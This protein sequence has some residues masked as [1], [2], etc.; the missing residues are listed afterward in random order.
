MSSEMT[1]CFIKL[2]VLI[3][4]CLVL[5]SCGIRKTGVKGSEFQSVSTLELAWNAPVD[6]NG[7][8]LAI[9]TGYRIYYGFASG[10][11][12]YSQDVGLVTQA[13]LTKLPNIPLYLAATDYDAAGDES[14]YSNEV[15]TTLTTQPASGS[16]V[17]SLAL[18]VHTTQN[19][20]TVATPPLLSQH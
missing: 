10:D 12:Q 15:Y 2:G 4:F 3:G 13:T 17:R 1:K 8:P 18:S 20:G 16:S 19:G 9:V 7:N 14:D 5:N 11:Y 6:S